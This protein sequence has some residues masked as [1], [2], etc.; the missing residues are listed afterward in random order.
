MYLVISTPAAHFMNSSAA[1]LLGLP[2]DI[3]S[4]QEQMFQV[5]LLGLTAKPAFSYTSVSGPEKD[6]QIASASVQKAAPPVE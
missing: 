2:A 1:A 6:C 5:E 4:P 3:A